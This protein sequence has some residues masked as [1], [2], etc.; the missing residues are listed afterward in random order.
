[1]S[2]RGLG[3]GRWEAAGAGRGGDPTG[4]APLSSGYRGH[5]PRSQLVRA[6]R[7]NP[8]EVRAEGLARQ[9]DREESPIPRRESDD[10][11]ANAGSGNATGNRDQVASPPAGGPA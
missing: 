4:R 3:T 5:P 1:M 10:R 2:W 7:G 9:A 8:V 11:E 6:E